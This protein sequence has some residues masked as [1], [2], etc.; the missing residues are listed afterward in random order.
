M[1]KGLLALYAQ[2]IICSAAS[3]QSAI[4]KEVLINGNKNISKD[5]IIA[6]M[7]MQQGRPYIDS[8]RARD[9]DAI[10]ELGFFKDADIIPR[11]I[12]DTDWQVMVE[13][14]ENP[15]I[16]E[17]RVAGG[18]VFK[19]DEIL[20]LVKQPANEVFNLRNIVPTANAI[21]DLYQKRGYFA[22]AEIAPLDSAPETLNIQIS[23]VRSMRSNSPI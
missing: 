2:I 18:T 11:Q 8:D 12:N 9:R 6:V 23:S 13:V 17:I 22:E 7:R 20:K 15:M 16:K 5:A 4:I 10:L 19:L 1:R 3:A 21:R 14:R